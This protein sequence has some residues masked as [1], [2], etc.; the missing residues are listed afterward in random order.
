MTV[1]NLN[2]V[3]ECEILTPEEG[4]AVGHFKRENMIKV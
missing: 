1:T 3:L 4:R 2:A